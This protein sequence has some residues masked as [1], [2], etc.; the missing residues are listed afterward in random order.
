[1]PSM[2]ST[3]RGNRTASR[4]LTTSPGQ[5][6]CRSVSCSRYSNPWCPPEFCTPCAGPGGGYQ[7]ARLAK[8]ITLLDIVEAVDGPIRGQV[9]FTAVNGSSKLFQEL[10]EVFDQAA[11]ETRRQLQKV[12]ISDLAKETG[13]K[14][15][16]S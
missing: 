15:R 6:V 2:P 9:D 13:K 12:K 8:E 3:R 7:L 14:S 5:K 16:A 4:L 11:A 10:K 1:M